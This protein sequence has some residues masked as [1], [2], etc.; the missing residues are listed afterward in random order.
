MAQSVKR[1]TPRDER[2]GVKRETAG[3]MGYSALGWAV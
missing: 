3:K 1:E 2:R